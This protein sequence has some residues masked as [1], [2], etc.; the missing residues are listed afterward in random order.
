MTDDTLVRTKPSTNGD[1]SIRPLQTTADRKAFL[2]VPYEAYGH[3]E[4]WRAPLR[5]ERAAQIDPAKNPSLA[6]MEHVLMVARRGNDVV[7]RVAAFINPAHLEVHKDAT[8]HFGFLDTISPD[9]EV[10]GALMQAAED[11]LRS[12]GMKRIAG[13]FNFSVNEECGL[14]VDGFDTPPVMMMPH[15]RPDYA[16]A[17]EACHYTKAM[18]LHA[19]MCSLGEPYRVPEKI[20]KL[21]EAFGRDPGLE[22]RMLNSQ[23][24][25]GEINLVLDIFDDAWSNNWGFVPFGKDEITHLANELK[26]LIR[27]D[28]LW[29]GLI[30]GE[31]ACFT[32]VL[33]NLNEA[34]EGLDGRLLPFGWLQLLHRLNLRGTR[35]ARLPLAGMR[36]KFHKTRRG[37]L[38]M[39]ASCEAAFAAQHARGVR[40]VE[41]SWI[42]ETNRD[43]IKLV[44]VYAAPRYK[45]YRIYDKAL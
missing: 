32:L 14:L 40:E 3:L 5:F 12:R 38:A 10:V 27:R 18:D 34:T 21:K 36:R 29:I 15:G 9:G 33:P 22:V 20:R 17:L 39:V 11:W 6:R 24:Y 31:P 45:T 25:K 2:E 7:G 8:G 16:P 42:L 19:Y 30:D 26:P 41:A 43:L 37:M 23:D 44:S 13:P 4:D 1:I 28:G 35:T